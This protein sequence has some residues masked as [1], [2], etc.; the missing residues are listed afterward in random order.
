MSTLVR[1]QHLVIKDSSNDL[2]KCPPPASAAIVTPK[3][4]QDKSV[5][6]PNSS[7]DIPFI[8]VWISTNPCETILPV[9]SSV[10][11]ADC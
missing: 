8:C 2:F 6:I 10:K 4:M 5:F 7:E 11:S 3:G 9:A 1:T